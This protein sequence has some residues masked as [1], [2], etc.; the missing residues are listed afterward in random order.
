M[1]ERRMTDA[2]VEKRL[3]LLE[4]EI[5]DLGKKVDALAKSTLLLKADIKDFLSVQKTYMELVSTDESGK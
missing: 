5:K 1:K 2:G 3:W 4:K